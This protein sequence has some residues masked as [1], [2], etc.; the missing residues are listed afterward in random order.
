[1]RGSLEAKGHLDALGSLSDDEGSGDDSEE[2]GEGNED[3]SAQETS[4]TEDIRDDSTAV[5]VVCNTLYNAPSPPTRNGRDR[6]CFSLPPHVL[7][8]CSLSKVECSV[9]IILGVIFMKCSPPHVLSWLFHIM[10][11]AL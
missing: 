10:F 9:I 2:E 3:N 6:T 4:H 11:F 1:M 7:G 5:R 8:G